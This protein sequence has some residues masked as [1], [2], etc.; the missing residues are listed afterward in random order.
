MA[1]RD[2]LGERRRS[3]RKNFHYFQKDL[4]ISNAQMEYDKKN[5]GNHF[6]IKGRGGVSYSRNLGKG[7]LGRQGTIFAEHFGRRQDNETSRDFYLQVKIC[8]P[9][10]I[11]FMVSDR[12]ELIVI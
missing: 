6:K 8:R 1:G 10:V 5:I 3:P 2:L 4:P 9:F 12:F 11:Y 7:G